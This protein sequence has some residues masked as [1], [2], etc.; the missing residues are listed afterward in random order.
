MKNYQVYLSSLKS[1]VGSDIA[2]QSYLFDWSIFPE[3][4]YEMTFAFVTKGENI[5]NAQS[6]VESVSTM[7]ELQ[8]PFMTDRYR[9]T[10]SGTAG[11]THI[12]GFLS[13][14][15]TTHHNNETLRQY[16]AHWSDNPPVTLRGKPQGN[17][18]RVRTLQSSGDTLGT[19]YN[20]DLLL[21]F[22]KI[23]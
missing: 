15:E 21:N 2:D 20:Y 9:A 11:G 23:G 4:E 10:S 12:S 17:T 13:F 7:I 16:R 18:I 14:Y 3:G 6:Q 19:M 1:G 22:K 5:T 8:V